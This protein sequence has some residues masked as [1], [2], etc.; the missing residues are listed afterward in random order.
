[1]GEAGIAAGELQ[2]RDALAVQFRQHVGQRL[3]RGAPGDAQSGVV[4]NVPG[5]IGD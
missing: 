2:H 1:M 4:V 3:Q 5:E